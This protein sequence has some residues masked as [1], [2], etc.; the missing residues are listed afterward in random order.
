VLFIVPPQIHP[1]EFGDESVNS[2][3]MA[4]V[5][6]AVIKGDLPVKIFWKLNG[7]SVDNVE[8]V[9]IMQTK[10]R[11]S[12]LT[13]DDV[14]AHHAGEYTC[15]ASNKAGNTSFS[16]YLRVN[17]EHFSCLLKLFAFLS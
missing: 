16:S 14:Q 11:V 5:N 2:G 12:Q 7:R 10:K 6:C 15:I 8:G 3:D 9:N 4:I 17:G 1:F 13:I